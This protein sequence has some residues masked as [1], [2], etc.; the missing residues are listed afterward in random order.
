MRKISKIEIENEITQ[1]DLACFEQSKFKI[2]KAACIEQCFGPSE[3]LKVN[4]TAVSN[5]QVSKGLFFFLQ[6]S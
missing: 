2:N 5:N 1:E 4:F 6:N 3:G